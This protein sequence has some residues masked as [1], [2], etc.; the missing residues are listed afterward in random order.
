[1]TNRLARLL[2]GDQN[3][4]PGQRFVFDDE[5]LAKSPL[6][7]KQLV[8]AIS[9]EKLLSAVPNPIPPN[10]DYVDP[11]VFSSTVTAESREQLKT[12][13]QD[14]AYKANT[15]CPLTDDELLDLT[16]IFTL[17]TGI[18]IEG[19][20]PDGRE[21]RAWTYEEIMNELNDVRAFMKNE[22]N[23]TFG[24]SGVM[25]Q[26]NE[27]MFMSEL[28]KFNEDQLA[29]YAA[30]FHLDLSLLD[31]LQTAL[32][33]TF[34]IANAK[35]SNTNSNRNNE[36]DLEERQENNRKT[37]V[38][39]L[40]SL[41][42]Q[43]KIDLMDRLRLWR[44]REEVIVGQISTDLDVYPG[45]PVTNYFETTGEI[46]ENGIDSYMLRIGEVKRET[47]MNH[48]NFVEL[49]HLA[50]MLAT[51]YPREV[52]FHTG[53]LYDDLADM[54]VEMVETIDFDQRQ[55]LSPI[56]FYTIHN[57]EKSEVQ[58]KFYNKEVYPDTE[59]LVVAAGHAGVEIYRDTE[60][61]ESTN[62]DAS[63]IDELDRDL[64]VTLR[65]DK[66]PDYVLAEEVISQYVSPQF[67]SGIEAHRHYQGAITSLRTMSGIIVE[68][69]GDVDFIFYGVGDG[70]SQYR[71]YTVK[72]LTDV[73]NANQDFFDPYSLREHPLLPQRWSRFSVPSINRLMRLVLPAMVER[74][75]SSSVGA[76]KKRQALQDLNV[77]IEKTFEAKSAQNLRL[78]SLKSIE[79]V[80]MRDYIQPRVQQARIIN[81]LKADLEEIRSDFAQ[82]L[83]Y[84][85]NTGMQFSDWSTE[86][87]Q[88]TQNAI[89][90]ALEEDPSWKHIDPETTSNLNEKIFRMLTMDFEKYSHIIVKRLRRDGQ[91]NPNTGDENDL[92]TE[93][94]DYDYL[95]RDLRI[96]KHYRGAYRL[97]WDDELATTEGHFFRMRKANDLSY[98][99]HLKTSG[100]WLMATAQYYSIEILGVALSSEEMQL[101]ELQTTPEQLI[102]L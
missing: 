87:T 94:E 57:S 68:Q 90:V 7:Q 34:V 24:L 54:V 30:L 65:H 25:A 32:S 47:L 59:A 102:E 11:Y 98:Y 53:M 33:E 70:I 55:L 73:F 39:Q 50:G 48:F 81:R 69:L 79:D 63:V 42:L 12:R 19:I 5:S 45:T 80:T 6:T 93:N 66:K 101:T 52:A 41:I 26:I 40:Q 60:V 56:D 82:F 71:V 97:E 89:Q 38:T 51:Y 23:T 74:I 58:Y 9:T 85:F 22:L 72:E 64:V 21:Y 88:I 44:W 36:S 20:T 62:P 61:L 27:C 3:F 77:T 86:M 4:F 76:D 8:A 1:M 28:D 83:V 43:F 15:E 31:E 95:L 37:Y 10:T 29:G 99:Q 16:L 46:F 67:F 92:V 91:S 75:Q 78:Q 18:D 100:N 96:V 49:Y 84:L 35:K 14:P 17:W 13:Q 2:S